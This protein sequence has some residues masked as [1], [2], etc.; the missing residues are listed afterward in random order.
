MSIISFYNVHKHYGAQEIL[1]DISFSIEENAKTGLIGPNGAGKTTLLKLILGKEEPTGGNISR[2]GD[3]RIGYVPQYPDFPPECTVSDALSL[4]LLTVKRKLREAEVA[5]STVDEDQIEKALGRYQRARDAYDAMNGDETAERISKLITS[6]GL[7]GKEDRQVATLSGGERNI[8]SLAKATVS[9]PELLI[10]DE[11]G[12][13]LD[14][15]GLDWLEEFLSSYPAAVLLVSHNRYLLDR[16]VTSIYELDNR[17]ITLYTGNYSEYRRAKLRNLVTAQSDYIANQKRLSRLEELVKRF[18]QIARNTADPM[19]GKRYRAR[20]TQ[21][22]KERAQ[23][24]EKPELD[25]KSMQVGW[26]GE[27]SQADIALQINGYSAGFDDTALF[28]SAKLQFSCGERIALVGP[29]G[30]GKT[31]LLKDIVSRGDWN[32]SV[33]RIGPSLT[34]GYC[35]Q[36]QEVFDP[37]KTILESFIELGTQNRKAT[38]KLLSRFLFT[39]NDLDK[40]IS[41][42]SGGEMNRLQ[43]AR[44]EALKANFLIL[45]EPTNHLDVGSKEAIEEALD[46]FNGTLLV[47]SHDRYF[48]DKVAD[49]VV[50]IR[51][52]KLEVFNGNFTEF[53]R[54][55]KADRSSRGQNKELGKRRVSAQ[56]QKRGDKPHNRAVRPKSGYSNATS[57]GLES[58]IE[59]HEQERAV[60]ETEITKAF[61]TGDHKRGRELSNKLEKVSRLIDKLYGEWEKQG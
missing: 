24:V 17:R 32:N 9:R 40:Q 1:S 42:L 19:W 56:G 39:W 23:A 6:F 15:V 26:N 44:V 28:D 34:V 49:T 22:E 41:S 53:W 33:L 7:D 5:L 21:L 12:N 30:S 14:Y 47:V 46:D 29:N 50:E 52:G 43:L 48:L 25:T 4:D 11:P 3:G 61:A 31:T 38:Y 36:N 27:R 8:L 54:T 59:R 60:L 51:N 57:T 20:R 13:H 10:L 18:E 35:A 16:V 55:K 45:D 37:G 2:D 58:R